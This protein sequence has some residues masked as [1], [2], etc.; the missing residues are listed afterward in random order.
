MRPFISGRMVA[1]SLGASEPTRLW[2]SERSR[3]T[4]AV[5]ST[6]CFCPP[7]PPLPPL[8]PLPPPPSLF[9]AGVAAPG[10]PARLFSPLTGTAAPKAGAKA[11]WVGW[12]RD[13]R[14]AGRGGNRADGNGHS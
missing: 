12:V 13:L 2:V 9:A 11:R 7:P 8:P 5:T 10:D 1:V 14:E 4:I 6:A 3:R